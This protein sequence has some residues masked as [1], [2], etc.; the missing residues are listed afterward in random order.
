M[1]NV[2]L[3]DDHAILRMGLTSLLG[4]TADIRVIGSASSGTEAVSVYERL[5]PDVV[6]MDLMM[7]DIDG[8]EATRRI[9]ASDAAKPRVLI[10]TTY[11]TADALNHALDYGARGA[12]LKNAEFPELCKAIRTIAEGGRYIM[13]DLRTLV[14]SELMIPELTARQKEVLQYLVDGHSNQDIAHSLQISAETVKDHIDII[15]AKLNAANR[16]EA[17]AIA[18]R[19]HLLKM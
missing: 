13:P 5:R 2:L 14:S 15:Y 19:K 17:V 12:I 4:T 6:L 18:L 8:A 1:I 16:T 11:A 9:L 7:P 3:V 10:F